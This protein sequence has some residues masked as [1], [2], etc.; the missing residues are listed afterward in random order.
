M[1]GLRFVVCVAAAAIV[2][3]FLMVRAEAT[4]L[5]GAVD[6]LAVLKTYSQPDRMHLRHEPLPSGHQMGLYQVSRYGGRHKE[7]C[8]PGLLG[9]AG[10]CH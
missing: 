8:L 10:S 9:S 7:M 1:T 4:P 3:G 2:G 6:S 5:T